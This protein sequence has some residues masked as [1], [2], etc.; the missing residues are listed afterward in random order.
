MVQVKARQVLTLLVGLTTVSLPLYGVAEEAVSAVDIVKRCYYKNAGNDQQTKLSIT[1][2]DKSGSEKKNV[3]ARY[4]KD[5]K[6]RDDIADK[7]L[8]TTEYPPDAEGSKFLRWAYT[9]ESRKN[10]DQWIYLPV[11]KKVRR[12]SV[13]DEGDSFLGSD[14]TYADIG[15]RAVEE[16]NHAFY[17]TDDPNRSDYYV[18][19]STPKE[20][21]SL[22]SRRILWFNKSASADDCVNVRIDYFDKKNNTLLKTQT[23]KW[24]RHDGAWV[25]DRVEVHNVQN[26]HRS[27]FEVADVKVNTGLDDTLLSERN[28][29]RKRAQ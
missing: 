14:L 26:D 10:A 1:L 4:W 27:I 21:S 11:L 28:L 17:E 29:L 9:R 2:K 20:A 24:Q 12:V 7:M 13:R 16:D 23:L 5:Y 19:E 18:I 22:Y 8:L 3:Y 25:W 6:G 15:M